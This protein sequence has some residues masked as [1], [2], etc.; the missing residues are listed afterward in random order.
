MEVATV[1]IQKKVCSSS[2]Y[3]LFGFL[4]KKIYGGVG[5]IKISTPKLKAFS[6]PEKARKL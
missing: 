4:V 5:G 2:L 6:S 3:S 1:C